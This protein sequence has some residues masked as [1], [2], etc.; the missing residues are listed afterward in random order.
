MYETKEPEVLVSA[1]TG[2]ETA[3]LTVTQNIS[4]FER[5]VDKS[6]HYKEAPSTYTTANFKW[7]AISAPI[8]SSRNNA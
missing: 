1:G 3:T 4:D 8:T 2:S 7:P 6:L 5:V